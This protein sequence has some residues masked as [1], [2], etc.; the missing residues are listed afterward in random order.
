M[1]S[2]RLAAIA[3]DFRKVGTTAMGAA[4]IGIFLSDH[5]ILTVYTFL[6]GAILWLIGICL[7]RED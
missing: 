4:L 7:T 2:K 6:S 5:Q 3:D 1:A